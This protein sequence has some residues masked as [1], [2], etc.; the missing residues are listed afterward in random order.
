MLKQVKS[1]GL[2]HLA[3]DLSVCVRVCVRDCVYVCVKDTAC[4]GM[5]SMIAS[6]TRSMYCLDAFLLSAPP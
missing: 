1:K 4:Q 2:C 6:H 5:R 3:A